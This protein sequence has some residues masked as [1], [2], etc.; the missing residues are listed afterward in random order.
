M[1]AKVNHIACASKVSYYPGAADDSEL[2][3]YDAIFV[4]QLP[5]SKLKI[6][7]AVVS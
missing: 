6:R 3:V 1:F 2:E 4:E 7:G 5:T